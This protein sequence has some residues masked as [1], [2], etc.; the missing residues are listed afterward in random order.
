[1]LIKYPALGETV[2]E[3][4]L[5]NGLLLRVVP[6][7]G[8]AKKHAF[9]A[10]DYGSIDTAFSV[11]G[12]RYHSAQGIAHYLEH[13]MFDMPDC[14][15][16]QLFSCYG[17]NP[18]AFTS[19]DITAYFVECTENFK[20]NLEL[21]LRYVSTGYFTQDSVEKERGIISQEIKMYE[22][23]PDSRVNENLFSAMYE[24]HPV[25]NSIAGTVESISHITAQSLYD[26]YNAFYIPENMM[27][28][29]VGDV[30][31]EYVR[32]AA[33]ELLP[34]ASH[35]QIITRDYGEKETM[36]PVSA[37]I[38]HEMEVSMPMFALGFKSEPAEHGP[39]SMEQEII[40]ELAAE[41]LMGESSALYTKMYE[42]QMIDAG[43]SCGYDGLKGMSM[44]TASGDSNNPGAV[45]DAIL[46]EAERIA[47]CGFDEKLFMRLKRS[48]LGR[49][50]RELDSFDSVCYRMCAYHFEGVD[51]FAFPE[52]FRNVT[53]ERVAQFL[54]KTVCSS[55]ACISV[56]KPKYRKV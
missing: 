17:G 54:K 48:S 41:I 4:R 39:E 11:N 45:L 25:K 27:L 9:L 22:D 26:C 21:L 56:V 3:E 35:K 32:K 55:R 1:M 42:K 46:E 44:L 12:K 10:V 38:E 2:F 23:N 37:K 5:S 33:E 24:K 6:K 52:I 14:N 20:E 43:F 7:P 51:Y 53:Q 28:C 13:K 49:R 29:V 34:K 31:P 8:F 19:Y 15:V 40:G 36:S 47:E 50:M 30:D 18:N 16:M